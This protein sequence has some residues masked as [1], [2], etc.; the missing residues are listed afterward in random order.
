[1]PLQKSLLRLCKVLRSMKADWKL[2][3]VK[4]S[5]GWGR[6]RTARVDIETRV[7]WW[8]LV[9]TRQ[10]ASVVVVAVARVVFVHPNLILLSTATACIYNPCLSSSSNPPSLF[11]LVAVAL[12]SQHLQHSTIT[13][14]PTQQHQQQHVWQRKGW[15]VRRKVW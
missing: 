14:N 4:E 11:E 13:T 8:C 7:V 9:K 6:R 2:W 5:C 1:M 3:T 15:Q 10:N 12:C